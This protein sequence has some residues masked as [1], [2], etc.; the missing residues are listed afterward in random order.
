MTMADPRSKQVLAMILT[1]YVPQASVHTTLDAVLPPEIVGDARERFIEN[2][3]PEALNDLSKQM[4]ALTEELDR[5]NLLIMFVR[6]LLRSRLMDIRLQ[7]IFNGEV[8]I[9]DQGNLDDGHVQSLRSRVSPFVNSKTF[10]DFMVSVRHRVC[11]IWTKA[12]N[13]RSGVF[14]GTGF[15]IAPDLV[16][17]A[18]HVIKSMLEQVP[19]PNNPNETKDRE[20]E[21]AVV[22]CIFDYWMNIYPDEVDTQ[23][24]SGIT[25]VE[26]APQWLVWYSRRHPQDGVSHTFPYPPDISKRLDCAVIRLAKSVG[27][28][29]FATGGGRMRGW[30]KLPNTG[31]AVVRNDPIAILQHPGGG[32][33]GMDKGTFS[34][35]DGS[36]TRIW[37]TT[38]AAA[39]SSGSPCFD[40]EADII[41][42]HNAGRPI[43]Y[44]G[45][46]KDCNQGVRM[47]Q[48]IAALP[49]D[50]VTRSRNGKLDE[51][52]L[53][54]L[55]DRSD[56]PIPVLGRTEFKAAVLKLFDPRAG[57]RMIVVD[58]ALPGGRSSGKSFS[59]GILKAI[60]RDRPS[61]VLEFSARELAKYNPEEFLGELCRRIGIDLTKHDPMP[62]KPDG[63]RQL[64]RWWSTELPEWFGQLL[65]ERAVP[66]VMAA[67]EKAEG[68]AAP[69]TGRELVIKELIWI[70]IDDIHKWPPVRGV[71]ELLAGMTGVTDTQQVLRAGLKA[72]RWLIIGHVPDFVRD[73]ASAFEPDTA[74]P[75]TIG[76]REWVECLRAYFLSSGL[77]DRFNEVLAEGLYDFSMEMLPDASDPEKRLS[78]IAA[79]IPKAICSFPA[80][81]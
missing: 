16:M 21:G 5:R 78:T 49:A 28:E 30:I 40:K 59:A 71:R 55:S 77:A 27:A 39:G 68:D 20:R 2:L 35:N 37:Y 8:A 34:D 26:A 10:G 29:A 62:A 46:T 65:E 69:A 23:Q 19:D 47:D 11:A 76:K 73:R 50:V 80:G 44:Q 1:R 57:K 56:Q 52:P 24:P 53:W 31:C 25:V 79:A 12:P 51:S 45:P 18:H 81:G 38:E 3:R 36:Q 54:S 7:G 74:S 66:A 22:K 41:G 63:D 9:D 42:F 61:L 70:V 60:A 33:Q 58:E 43:G 72:I 14:S 15:L 64:A 75:S 32:P 6:T 67:Q 4:E 13:A 48:V 17:T